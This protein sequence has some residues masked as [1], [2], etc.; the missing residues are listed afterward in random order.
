M[1]DTTDTLYLTLTLKLPGQTTS[2]DIWRDYI[3]VGS[4]V[5]QLIQ[6]SPSSEPK[7]ILYA[8]QNDLI[9]VG[10]TMHN[11]TIIAS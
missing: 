10:I 1:W 7:R 8:K 2:L 4:S 11:Q 9:Q 6:L 5:V 3:A